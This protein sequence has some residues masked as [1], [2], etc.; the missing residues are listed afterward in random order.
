MFLLLDDESTTPEFSVL[1]YDSEKKAVRKVP[2][3]KDE[4]LQGS[5]TG[6]KNDNGVLSL[7]W[8]NNN[9]LPFFLLE[10]YGECV[11]QDMEPT[12]ELFKWSTQ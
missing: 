11:L 10:V 3:K 7:S 1:M 2:L 9:G 8:K 6:Q 5:F 4:V 12:A